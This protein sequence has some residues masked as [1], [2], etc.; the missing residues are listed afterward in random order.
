MQVETLQ[1]GDTSAERAYTGQHNTIGLKYDV[2]LGRNHNGV[3]RSLGCPLHGFFDA[4]NVSYFVVYNGN[5]VLDVTPENERA[6]YVME[7][8]GYQVSGIGS[9]VS[10]ADFFFR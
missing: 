5:H 3:A 1:V 8:I 6:V 2:L 9:Q 7:G 4:A 10:G